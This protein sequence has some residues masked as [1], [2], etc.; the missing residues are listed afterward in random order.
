MSKRKKKSKLRKI[1]D[2]IALN[3]WFRRSGPIKN[4]KNN[5]KKQRQWKQ[6]QNKEE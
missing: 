5:I 6:K 2:W 3:A 1:R 4:K